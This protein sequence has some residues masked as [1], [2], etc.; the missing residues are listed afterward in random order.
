MAEDTVVSVRLPKDVAER[1]AA[2]ADELD[3]PRSWLIQQAIGVYLDG[4]AA[5]RVDWTVN[6]EAGSCGLPYLLQLH[7]SLPAMEGCDETA[8][9]LR[10]SVAAQ[11]EAAGARE[12]WTDICGVRPMSLVRNYIPQVIHVSPETMA[13]MREVRVADGPVGE[14]RDHIEERE[15]MMA[16]LYNAREALR[17]THEYVGEA[18]LPATPGWSWF[19]AIEAIDTV[20]GAKPIDPNEVF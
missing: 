19:D 7:F 4:Q 3:R 18:V 20:L 14:P 8:E 9:D 13:K 15:Q 17:L 16:C 12:V 10:D 6:D 5:R 11:L 2:Q 1:L